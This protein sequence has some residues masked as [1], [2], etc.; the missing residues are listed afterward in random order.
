MRFVHPAHGP[1]AVN[2]TRV[3]SVLYTFGSEM[4]TNPWVTTTLHMG[5]DVVVGP[6]YGNS[7]YSTHCNHPL[8]V[9]QVF[10]AVYSG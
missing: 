7:F 3:Q 4:I 9:G 8:H 6:G 1:G 5:Q 10:V 2:P